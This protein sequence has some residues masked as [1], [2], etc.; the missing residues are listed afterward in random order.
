MPILNLVFPIARPPSQADHDGW[1]LARAQPALHEVRTAPRIQPPKDIFGTR[2][3]SSSHVRCIPHKLAMCDA[4]PAS[5]SAATAAPT[6]SPS[7]ASSSARSRPS[8]LLRCS[9]ALGRSCSCQ[10]CTWVSVRAADRIVKQMPLALALVVKSPCSS[11]LASAAFPSLGTHRNRHRCS[12]SNERNPRS[13]MHALVLMRA[14]LSRD[15]S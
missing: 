6:G 9:E 2:T 10:S 1:P 7:R 8:S 13:L 5:R 4:C 15:L 3:H 14:V 11:C 12:R